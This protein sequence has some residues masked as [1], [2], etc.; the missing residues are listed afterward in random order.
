MAKKGAALEQLIALVQETLKDRPDTVIE[1]NAKVVDESNITREIDVLVSST[2][3]NMPIQIAFECKDYSKK[4]VDIKVIDAFI[5]KC[6]HLPHIHKKVIVST[7]GFTANATKRA[8]E[9]GIVLCSL[10]EVPMEELFDDTRIFRAIPIYKLGETITLTYESENEPVDVDNLESFDCYLTHDDSV[11]DFRAE[12]YRKLA[13][14]KTQMELAKK[15]ME[16]GKKAFVSIVC[17]KFDSSLYVKSKN[18]KKLNVK[19]AQIPVF[20][21]FTFDNGTVVKQQKIVQGGDVYITE[22]KFESGNEQFT[23]LV[24]ANEK[25]YKVL[26]K[27]N[28]AFVEPS[29]RID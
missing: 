28:D 7:S 23:T 17:F 4:A 10:E 29:M 1:T 16:K 12:T 6:K 22:N 9:E 19:E 26:F 21:D 25:K 20:V 24:I 11:F 27:Q 2:L 15:Y 8:N 14:L 5:G 3:Q 13:N 18:G